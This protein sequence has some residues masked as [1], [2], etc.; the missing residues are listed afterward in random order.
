MAYIALT[1]G[2]PIPAIALVEALEKHSLLFFGRKNTFDNDSHESLE[3]E[4]L[5]NNPRVTFIPTVTGR[6]THGTNPLTQV[7]KTIRAIGEARKWLKKYRP[8]MVVAF[9]GYIAVP[10]VLAARSL[11]IRVILHEQTIRP[12]RANL[13]LAWFSGHIF[14]AF[15]EAA[16][17]FPTRKTTFSGNPYPQSFFSPTKPDWYPARK[18]VVLVMGGSGGSHIINVAVE[19][20]RNRYTIIHQTGT[21]NYGDFERLSSYQNEQYI[22]R[23]HISPSHL[24]YCMK[25]ADVAITRAGANT[26]FLLCYYKLPSILIPL[27][28]APRGEQMEHATLIE[29]AGAGIVLKENDLSMLST[30]VSQALRQSD[31]MKENFRNLQ[32]YAQSIISGTVFAQNLEI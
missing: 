20:L 28:I 32:S 27:G 26:F 9:G 17:S 14:T 5:K 4:M 15:Q 6:F 25:H 24:A 11:G 31:S 2:H 30:T 1:G 16:R 7:A 3:Y 18:P 13:F 23:D 10:V 19:K 8:K 12:G 22:V 29:H 21:S